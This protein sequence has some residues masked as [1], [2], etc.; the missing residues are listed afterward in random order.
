MELHGLCVESNRD[1]AP[2]ISRRGRMQWENSDEGR[3]CLVFMSLSVRLLLA[4]PS[5]EWQLNRVGQLA[6]G[7]VVV[8]R[9]RSAAA[10]Q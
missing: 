2:R 1:D 8:R 5:A 6:D 9:G 3:I 4:P 10:M 7:A